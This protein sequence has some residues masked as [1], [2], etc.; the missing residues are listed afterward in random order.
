M[1]SRNYENTFSRCVWNK[2]KTTMKKKTLSM[3]YFAILAMATL[4]LASCSKSVTDDDDNTAITAGQGN[5]NLSIL[6]RAGEGEGSV[7]Y[8]V[9]LYVFNSSNQCV[10]VKTLADETAELTIEGLKADTYNVFA[11]GGADNTRYSLPTQANATPTTLIT[12]LEGKVHEDLMTGRNTVVIGDDEDNQLT[13]AL[14]RKVAMVKQ[15]EVKMVPADA[16]AVS[17]VITPLREAFQLNGE[18]SGEAGSFTQD[19]VKQ[20]DNR[21]WKN[22][23]E[24]YMLPSVGNATIT[25]KMTLDGNVRSYSYTCAEP[26]LANYK[27]NIDAT[28]TGNTFNMTGTLTGATWEGERTITFEFNED[29][30]TGSEETTQGGGGNNEGGNGNE[31]SGN[32][33]SGE[34]TEGSAPAVG[35]DYQGAYVLRSVDNGNTVTVTLMSAEDYSGISC[36]GKT[37]EQIKAEVDEALINLSID[38]V[39]GWRLPTKEELEYTYN[40][41]SEVNTKLSQLGFKSFS[42]SQNAASSSRY[43]IVNSEGNYTG[44]DVSNRNEINPNTATIVRAFTTLTFNK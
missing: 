36:N 5:S 8:P 9:V 44:C 28:Y 35:T 12:L 10:A 24:Q 7:A 18:Y 1:R 19:L 25:I 27:L 23:T 17:L 21:T 14:Q 42:Y 37:Q 34:T 30:G 39:D 29:N 3:L 33:P 2:L 43:F 4:C 20:S 6:T 26:L 38:A 40:N 15:V 16:E 41:R 31:G 32:T 13:L 11:I 22:A